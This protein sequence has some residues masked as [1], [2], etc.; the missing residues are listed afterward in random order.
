MHQ[1]FREKERKKVRI[2][3]KNENH[4]NGAALQPLFSYGQNE[5]NKIYYF[6][7]LFGYVLGLSVIFHFIRG[8]RGRNMAFFVQK[9]DNQNERRVVLKAGTNSEKYLGK[10][11]R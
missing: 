11:K 5:K 10:E 1:Q 4:V 6:Y 3:L 8:R 7:Q 9:T 2:W